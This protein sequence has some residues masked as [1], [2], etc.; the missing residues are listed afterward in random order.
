MRALCGREICRRQTVNPIRLLSQQLD[1][2]ENSG[3]Y[4]H[5]GADNAECKRPIQV[6]LMFRSKDDEAHHHEDN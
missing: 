4:A 2:R 6:E 3:D 5:T 1:K